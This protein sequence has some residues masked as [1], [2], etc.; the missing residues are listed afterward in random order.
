VLPWGYTNKEVF[1]IVKHLIK[2][3]N[4]KAL[5]ID[6]SLLQTAGLDENTLFQIVVD[7]NGITI[8]SVKPTNQKL[9]K[10][11]LNKIMNKHDK[12]FKNLSNR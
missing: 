5:V 3:G 7:V 11:S 1:V 8:Q 12:L 6:K 10:N 4:S 2:H 9:F